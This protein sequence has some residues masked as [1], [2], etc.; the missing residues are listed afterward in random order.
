MML[1]CT[2]WHG[3]AGILMFAASSVSVAQSETEWPRAIAASR[4]QS[5]VA[6][7]FMTQEEERAIWDWLRSRPRLFKNISNLREFSHAF[8]S[9]RID[10]AFFPIS[11]NA[12]ALEEIGVDIDEE[13]EP[14]TGAAGYRAGTELF[15]ILESHDLTCVVRH[16]KLE[17]TTVED[18]ETKQVTRV[19]D[20]TPLL[21][22]QKRQ[23]KSVVNVSTLI[24]TIYTSIKPDSWE[25]LGG[26]ATVNSNI[27]NNRCLLTISAPTMVHIEVQQLLDQLSVAGRIPEIRFSP[28]EIQLGMQVREPMPEQTHAPARAKRAGLPLKSNSLS[29]SIPTSVW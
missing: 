19:Y 11:L 12:K 13:L 29:D 17:V 28:S 4:I 3:L 18:A 27:L 1:R 10:Q 23:G 25:M 20:V 15:A 7:P 2:V 9:Q 14:V 24:E 6:E 5:W 8:P 26:S 16:G 21:S 22:I